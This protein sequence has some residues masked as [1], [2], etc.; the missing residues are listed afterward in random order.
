MF[1][2]V[3]WLVKLCGLVVDINVSEEHTASIFRADYF[4]SSFFKFLVSV[5]ETF[6][7]ASAKYYWNETKNP[8]K[9]GFRLKQV[10]LWPCI[11]VKYEFK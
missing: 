1:M 7:L 8:L 3:I 5:S 6:T 2:L 9:A 11:T 10:P 4:P